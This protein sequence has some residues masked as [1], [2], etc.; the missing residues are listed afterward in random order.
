M[1]HNIGQMFYFGEQPWHKLGKRLAQPANLEEAMAAGGLNWTVSMER[2]VLMHEH[3][4]EAP[5]RQAIVRDDVPPGQA[6]RVLGVVHPN[7]KVLQNVD[8]AELFDSLFGKGQRVYHTGGHLKKG[9]VVWLMAKLPESIVLPGEDKLDTYLLFSN[10]HDGTLPI[11]IRL[12]TVRVVCNNTLSI[13]LRKKDQAHVFRRSHSGSHEVLKAEAEAFFQAVLAQQSETT[14]SMTKLIEAGCTD[15]AFAAFLEKLLPEPARPATADTNVAVGRSHDTRAATIAQHR[16]QIMEVHLKGH[17]VDG[18]PG[19][20]IQPAE[21]NWWGG[22][23]SITA[24]VDHVCEIDGDRYA[25]TM[26]GTGDR[27]KTDAYQRIL[28]EAKAS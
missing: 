19:M 11:D 24:W 17:K 23:N 22:L 7:F 1:A 10:S 15:D 25:N 9:E 18:T 21:K 16:N 20:D 28:E 8:G 5:Q 6:G 4:S 13:A 26:F 27:L 12:T 14:A 2:L 3:Q